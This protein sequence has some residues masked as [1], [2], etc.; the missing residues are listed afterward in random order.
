MVKRI[1][2]RRRKSALLLLAL[3]PACA[4]APWL[5]AAPARDEGP[6]HMLEFRKVGESPEAR[7][8]LLVDRMLRVAA[9]AASP[10]DAQG[11]GAQEFDCKVEFVKPGQ[12][13]VFKAYTFK[14]REV[15]VAI[16]ESCKDFLSDLET[17]RSLMAA[18]LL[19]RCGLEAELLDRGFPEWL[20]SGA[21]RKAA[22]SNWMS[23][24]PGSSG[25]QA[26][27]ALGSRGI[28]PDLKTVLDS[29]LDPSYGECYKVYAEYCEA[30]LSVCSRNGLLDK[31]LPSKMIKAVADD[32]GV[33]RFDLFVSL[34][35]PY[36]GS[37]RIP[38]GTPGTPP[39]KASASSDPKAVAEAA[40]R[41]E[42]PKPAT[43]PWS[44]KE[45]SAWFSTELRRLVLS[46]FSPASVRYL[47]TLFKEASRVAYKD[48]KGV[49]RVCEVD[50][51]QE[52]W[53]SL[54]EP[55]LIVS[56]MKSKVNNLAN[57]APPALQDSL[58]GMVS[59]LNVILVKRGS[60]GASELQAAKK[61]FYDAIERSA[62]IE[63]AMKKA[64]V[65]GFPPTVRY[66]GALEA[67]KACD[68][69][70]EAPYAKEAALLD[71]FVKGRR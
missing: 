50:E 9:W 69:A 43:Q 28:F 3:L 6:V 47:E 12:G 55:E 14:K 68:L 41:T 23:N 5:E 60:A 7:A 36:L 18:M 59:A 17:Q 40:R 57:F 42:K 13:S 2:E 71:A 53:S 35:G 48:S 4:L 64:E 49:E 61:A 52:K 44:R 19:A 26:A 15:R 30:V 67:L 51:L 21:L 39:P 54:G 56:E 10:E 33:S 22:T 37:K 63:A 70:E 16:A 20:S 25:L 1:M 65:K 46:C 66:A 11:Q 58:S 34:A 8:K 24:L 38:D 45:V 32:P 31:G 62:A 27:Y 29:P